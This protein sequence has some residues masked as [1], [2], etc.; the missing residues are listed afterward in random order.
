METEINRPLRIVYM[1]TPPFAVQPLR[2]LHDTEEVVLVI[3][4]PD[5]PAGRGRK[6]TACAVKEEA[7]N[8]GVPVHQPEKVRDEETLRVLK[9]A[10]CDLIVVAAF[11]QILPIEVLHIPLLGC[12]N[13]HASLLPK[14]RGASPISSAIVQGENITG[15]TTMMMD[16]GMDTGDILLQKSLEISEHD[17]AGTLSDR[18]SRL[19]AEAMAETLDAMKKRTLQPTRQKESGATYTTLLTKKQGEIDWDQE[20]V[21]I[22]NLVR[23]MDPWPGAYTLLHGQ[24]LKIWR[25]TPHEG[26]GDP[27]RVLSVQDHLIIGAKE[28]SLVIHE[29]QL[30]GK[31]RVSGPDYLRGHHALKQ[32]DILGR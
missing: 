20:P 2:A 24:H 21:R 23:G 26:K 16:E 1:G 32:G 25:V 8:L 30:P 27:G 22:C 17:T 11:G 10:S 5:R 29:L 7:V 28:G 19:G 18:L 15:V 14:Y 3:T 12:M 31:K 6:M 4:Q 13:I 9:E